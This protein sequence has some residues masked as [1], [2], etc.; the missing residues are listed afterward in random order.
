MKLL[1]VVFILLNPI[2]GYSQLSTGDTTL[3]VFFEKGINPKVQIVGDNVG[4]IRSYSNHIY[5]KIENSVSNP[6]DF[7]SEFRPLPQNLYVFRGEYNLY[8]GYSMK[9]YTLDNTNPK[10]MSKKE[11]KNY[12]VVTIDAIKAFLK[13]NYV[14]RKQEEYLSPGV[15]PLMISDLGPDPEGS[16]SFWDQMKAIFM[17]EPHPEKKNQFL[18]YEV[19]LKVDIE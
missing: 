17:V 11:L 3:Y 18:L 8:G 9:F 13:E 16:A 19:R 10:V 2:L 6:Q 7:H 1:F 12:K 15:D 5:F 4:L 14:E